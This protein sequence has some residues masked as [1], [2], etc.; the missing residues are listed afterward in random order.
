VEK[1]QYEMFD[2]VQNCG[3]Y[4]VGVMRLRFLIWI[5]GYWLS[6]YHYAFIEATTFVCRLQVLCTTSI[7]TIILYADPKSICAPV[8]QEGRANASLPSHLD[9]II[10]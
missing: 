7:K 9:P 5:D 10:G 2:M 8:M 6:C 1:I 3:M 4:P